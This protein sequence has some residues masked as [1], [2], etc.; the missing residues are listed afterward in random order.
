MHSPMP[1]II[2]FWF[3]VGQPGKIVNK[4][5][6]GGFDQGLQHS[7]D[8]YMLI[9]IRQVRDNEQVMNAPSRM[10]RSKESTEM[11]YEE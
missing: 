5:I 3:E 7:N 11:I 6:E 4:S 10:A 9:R 1:P 2:P 8:R